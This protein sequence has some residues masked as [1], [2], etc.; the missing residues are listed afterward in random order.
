M[1]RFSCFQAS[2]SERLAGGFGKLPSSPSQEERTNQKRN[3]T[4]VDIS[5]QFDALI[6][7]TVRLR[8]VRFETK[9]ITLVNKDLLEVV[10]I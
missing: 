8:L 5:N 3:E 6:Y 10:S 9:K 7:A 1:G 4:V 2:H